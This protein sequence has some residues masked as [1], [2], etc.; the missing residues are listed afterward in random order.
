M[1]RLF[2]NKK[3]IELNSNTN[4]PLSKTF[5][6][7]NN[8][9][10]YYSEYSKT[11]DIPFTQKNN[12]FFSEYYN[13]DSLI[14]D[15]DPSIT[16]EYILMN[17]NDVLSNGVAFLDNI[18]FN[19]NGNVYQIVLQGALNKFINSLVES[20]FD[21]VLP[22]LLPNG[23]RLNSNNVVESW[24]NERPN[25]EMLF[26][27]NNNV[28][29]DTEHRW[30]DI[31]QFLPVNN[32]LLK[33]FQ[34][35]KVIT[36]GASVFKTIH[37]HYYPNDNDNE[38]NLE[39][40]IGDGFTERQ[41]GEFRVE[42]EKPVIYINKLIQLFKHLS[43]DLC[44]YDMVLDNRFFNEY[45][46]LYT[47][48]VYTL[49]DL[50]TDDN[51][52]DI[53]T[54]LNCVLNR[55]ADKKFYLNTNW[56][57]LGDT[58]RAATT[59][60]NDSVQSSYIVPLSSN[61]Y[62]TVIGYNNTF[63]V[64]SNVSLKLQ[65]NFNWDLKFRNKW[66]DN[67]LYRNRSANIN[68]DNA[69]IVNV[70]VQ[71]QSTSGWSTILS[72]K[73]LYYRDNYSSNRGIHWETLGGYV[74]HQTLADVAPTNSHKFYTLSA[75]C[76][77]EILIG[78]TPGTY[79]IG[80]SYS[81]FG[82]PINNSNNVGMSPYYP[83]KAYGLLDSVFYDGDS[84]AINDNNFTFKFL[85][86]STKATQEIRS[87]CNITTNRLWRDSL[88]PFAVVL[89][90]CKLMGIIFDFDPM[91]NVIK[92]IKRDDY[93]KDYKILDWTNKVDTSGGY[94][95]KPLNWDSKFVTFNYNDVEADYLTDY[96]SKYKNVL[97]SKKIQT[98]FKLNNE[99]ND[100]L[101]TSD[102]DRITPS[103]VESMFIN[104]TKNVVNRTLNYEQVKEIYVV[105]HKDG[106]QANLFGAFYFRNFNIDVDSRINNQNYVRVCGDSRH[107]I[108]TNQYAFHPY[109]ENG[110]YRMRKIPQLSVYDNSMSYNITF[111]IP[112]EL[113]YEKTL[114]SDTTNVK[115]M[116][117]NNWKRYIEEQYN[118]QNKVLTINVKLSSTEY[119]NLKHNNFVKINDVIYF[120]NKIK[121]YKYE[122]ELTKVEMVQ[123]YDI[124][125]Y[126]N[127][128][129]L[130]PK[131]DEPEPE[132][133]PRTD[134]WV[135]FVYD[136][137]PS[138]DYQLFYEYESDKST[139]KD[140]VVCMEVDGNVQDFATNIDKKS[141][142]TTIRLYF[143]GP[144]LGNKDYITNN[145]RLPITSI[146][147]SD[148]MED[149][150]ILVARCTGNLHY[151]HVSKSLKR[152][153][154][155]FYLLF[156]T[157]QNDFTYVLGSDVDYDFTFGTGMPQNIYV[158]NFD[159]EDCKFTILKSESFYGGAFGTIKLPKTLN[160]IAPYPFY[161][162][163]SATIEL[164]CVTPPT[165]NGRLTNTNTNVITLK[166]P[167]ESLELYRNSW[168]NYLQGV[169]L[170]GY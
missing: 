80:V 58:N 49:G 146:N 152:I 40:Y 29:F 51:E 148:N 14:Y 57:Y 153:G 30:S 108:E 91:Q 59:N 34:N 23:F 63:I 168:S 132:P 62:N 169:T 97:G 38:I 123:I 27:D 37:D 21:D 164:P 142:K 151:I 163:R 118:K 3:E 64:P 109:N 104:S 46:P 136:D 72:H 54:T 75:N 166:V 24:N 16:M 122:N 96:K 33:N 28:K 119:A 154:Q 110:N 44:G 94:D 135:E 162:V 65:Y 77:G 101:C 145:K 67:I 25:L 39:S 12:N 113:Y 6:S 114:F 45:N 53:D 117:E 130:V 41:N 90:Y 167:N 85:S 19:Q 20:S 112:K 9:T 71:K 89:Q 92:L 60:G 22:N 129:K 74:T 43:K 149:I 95:I 88:K 156:N 5:E 8:P 144:V 143:N 138:E 87:D 52:N 13:L 103:C 105:N 102:Y 83:F 159:F 161:N 155:S 160:K 126:T 165:L 15:F 56:V 99:N 157:E 1:I 158:G 17:D 48:V 100:L 124:S 125:N 111:S 139:L 2:L 78:N 47:D 120:V 73:H 32:G 150:K 106:K 36:D 137:E 70:F 133:D 11:V 84:S 79:R 50:V 42:Y 115:D 68:D 35:N 55:P 61:D 98:Q 140:S 4:F 93:F 116:Y 10:L 7:L 69:F 66:R 128:F 76:N 147:M 26:D 141:Q 131:G 170:V 82:N 86:L 107:E 121:D 134:Y 127:T 31:I 18:K 81:F